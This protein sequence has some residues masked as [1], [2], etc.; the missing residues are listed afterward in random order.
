MA[1]ADVG[2]GVARGIAIFL[3]LILIMTLPPVWRSSSCLH[4]TNTTNA[5][6]QSMSGCLHPLYQRE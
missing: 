2:K 3:L 4:N 1:V 6:F 5:V